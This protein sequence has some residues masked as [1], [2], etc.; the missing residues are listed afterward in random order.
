MKPNSENSRR[1]A[2]YIYS[3]L[4]P[5]EIAEMEM[6]IADDPELSESYRMNMMVKDY[7]KVKVQLESM[8]NDPHLEEAEKLAQNAFGS[9][10]DRPRKKR[11]SI[12]FVSGLAAA[13][14]ILV[15]VG[16]IT[17]NTN[18]TKLYNRYYEPF[19]ASDYTQRGVEN[20]THQDIA[21]AMRCN[22]SPG[23][24]I[25]ALKNFL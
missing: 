10:G 12:V 21:E 16:F 4:G 18:T 3:D 23:S 17:I 20:S 14:A 1:L 9:T 25:W 24:P 22:F 6:E 13:I 15:T 8:R 7:L 11:N 5:E 19:N 2:D